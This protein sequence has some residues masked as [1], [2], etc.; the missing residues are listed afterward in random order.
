MKL[1]AK[2]NQGLLLLLLGFNGPA[3]DAEPQIIIMRAN[4]IH[5]R[6]GGGREGKKGERNSER[7]RVGDCMAKEKEEDIGRFLL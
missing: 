7:E 4:E 6:K 1:P 5:I 2:E 3:T